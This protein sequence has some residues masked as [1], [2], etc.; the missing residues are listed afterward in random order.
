L[1]RLRSNRGMMT[2]EGL[3]ERKKS[4]TKVSPTQ[5]ERRKQKEDAQGR[6]GMGAGNREK[7]DGEGLA[8]RR[9]IFSK[10]LKRQVTKP[11]NLRRGA[12]VETSSEK[13]TEE[14]IPGRIMRI[15]HHYSSASPQG[16][17][18]RAGSSQTGGRRPSPADLRGTRRSTGS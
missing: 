14:K 5:V 3:T 11:E 6:K 18:P 17:L 10:T 7:L 12:G 16:D 4:G 8:G 13:S 9:M 15:I 1:V 2:R